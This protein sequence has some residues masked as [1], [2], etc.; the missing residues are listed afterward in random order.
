MG[1]IVAI[2]SFQEVHPA[3]GQLGNEIVLTVEGI[4]AFRGSI[5]SNFHTNNT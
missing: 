2:K 4:P 1:E 3:Q 5:E